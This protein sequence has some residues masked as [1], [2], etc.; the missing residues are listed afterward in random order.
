VMLA[1][2]FYREWLTDL[3][4]LL[5]IILAAI[6]VL[7]FPASKWQNWLHRHRDA[8]EKL[9]TTLSE[10]IPN[11]LK[12]HESTHAS[13]EF[14]M[15]ELKPNHGTS[16]KDAVNRIEKMVY[17]N[18]AMQRGILSQD[19]RPIF[20]A[21]EGGLLVWCNTAYLDLTNR[22]TTE[23]LGRGY[24]NVVEKEYQESIREQAKAAIE[25]KRDMILYFNLDTGDPAF[26]FIP[27]EATAVPIKTAKGELTGYIGS[28]RRLDEHYSLSELKKIE[29]SL[30]RVET[31]VNSNKD[32][33]KDNKY[34]ITNLD[35]LEDTL[36][37]VESQIQMNEALL[38]GWWAQE[39]KPLW[40]NDA[41]GDCIWV[42][43]ASTN[44]TKKDSSELMKKGWVN[45]I[46]EEDR[47]RVMREHVVGIKDKREIVHRFK[48]VFD[49]MDTPD[50]DVETTSVPILTPSGELTG[51]LGTIKP[52]GNRRKED[53]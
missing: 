27:V 32:A 17:K 39:E 9:D 12:S 31:Q 30:N 23:L 45:I 37:R 28:I 50:I 4:L 43:N 44:F 38:R 7:K 51:Y 10:I 33:I 41:H 35:R 49:D 3:S 19:S 14:I 42:N 15:S 25:D 47:E 1:E 24:L 22:D 16:L 48:M 40:I 20:I 34:N 29:E 6:G 5:G 26:P 11:L 21:D 13:L 36:N 2:V 46:A 53:G 18:E 52:I 8:R